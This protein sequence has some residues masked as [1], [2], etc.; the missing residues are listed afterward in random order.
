MSHVDEG[1]VTIN[2]VRYREDEL[3]LYGLEKP[4]PAPP[5]VVSTPVVEPP[6]PP[7]DPTDPGEDGDDEP[8]TDPEK[9]EPKQAAG[10]ANKGRGAQNKAA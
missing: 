5:V 10:R 9:P 6:E 3:G 4:A 2:G 1:M 8:P 7:T